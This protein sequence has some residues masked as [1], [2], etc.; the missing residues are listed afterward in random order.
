MTVLEKDGSSA[1][2]NAALDP[3]DKVIIGSSKEI[4]PGDKVR[5]EE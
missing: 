1:A 2:V 5:L 3:D 4:A